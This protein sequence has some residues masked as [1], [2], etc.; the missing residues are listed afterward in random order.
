MNDH[1][2]ILEKNISKVKQQM[3]LTY[4]FILKTKPPL[5]KFQV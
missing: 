1:H 5:F 2:S 3:P 4:I